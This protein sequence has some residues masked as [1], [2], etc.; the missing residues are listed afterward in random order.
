MSGCEVRAVV[1]SRG[2]DVEFAVPP[3]EVLAILG[4]NGAG[5][6][7][8]LHVIAG[9]VRPDPGSVRVGDRVLTDSSTGTRVET[10]DRRIGLL[11]QD[12]LLFPHLSVSANVAFGARSGN[13]LSRK[14]SHDAAGHWLAEVEAA[15]LAHRRPRRLS[16]GQ[17]QRVALARALAADPDVLLLDEPLAGLDVGTAAAMRA[18]L[19]RV[20][21]RD[22]RSSVLV[23]HDLLDVVTLADRVMVLESGRIAEAGRTADVVAAPRSSFGARFAGINLVNGR[24]GAGPTLVTSWQQVWHGRPDDGAVR[25]GEPVTATFHPSAVAVYRDEP[26][27][28]PRNT[29]EVVIAELDSRGPAIRVRADQQPD[30][31]PGL[32]ADITAE[33]ASDLRLGPGQ[34]VF[35][36]VKSQE[37]AIHPAP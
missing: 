12:P 32:S 31:S 24:A 35:F 2:L 29:V 4:P 30:G 34:R 21:T 22:G 1:E 3:G 15:D 26:H 37:V 27:G 33:S 11:M 14:V 25:E 8:V 9:L 23:T 13:R 10:Y 5:K 7:T 36:T 28:S 20:L 17:A 18:V 16:G 6:S 19:R